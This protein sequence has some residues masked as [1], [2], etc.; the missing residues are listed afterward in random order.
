MYGVISCDFSQ[1]NTQSSQLDFAEATGVVSG[2]G[3]TLR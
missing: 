1:V 3:M 2:L